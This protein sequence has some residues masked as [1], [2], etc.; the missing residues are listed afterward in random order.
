METSK[1]MFR[2]PFSFKG[3][4][5]RLEFGLS[6]LIYQVY[7]I[8]ASPF[9][10]FESIETII[11][12]LILLT[13]IAWFIAAQGAKRCHDY[14]NSGWWQLVPFYFLWMLF[15]AGDIDENYYGSP[16]K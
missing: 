13:P 12:S 9:L 7:L 11:L 14:E 8:L 5:R 15:E 4:I 3:R 16:P 10:L 2:R 6:F 1:R